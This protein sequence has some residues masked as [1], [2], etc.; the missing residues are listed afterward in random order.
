LLINNWSAP[1]NYLIKRA[2]A[3]K[4]RKMNA[5]NPATP[6][7]QDREYFTM[8]AI[9]GAR[10]QYAA[11][12]LSVY[13]RWSRQSVSNNKEKRSDTLQVLLGNFLNKI[14]HNTTLEMPL[15]RIYRKIII[16]DKLIDILSGKKVFVRERDLKFKNIY[17]PMVTNS[18]T[19]I[20]LFIALML[21]VA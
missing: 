2:V 16:T 13:N 21:N 5:W 14:E 3:E 11:G 7:F 4:L 6:V 17:W 18:T 10:F 20:K 1:N 12:N 8:G 15:K 19:K 9:L